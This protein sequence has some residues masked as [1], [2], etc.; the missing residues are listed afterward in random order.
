M[1]NVISVLKLKNVAFPKLAVWYTPIEPQDTLLSDDDV[2]DLL[3][4]V[5]T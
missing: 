4:G 5:Q 3:Q 2:V 1:K